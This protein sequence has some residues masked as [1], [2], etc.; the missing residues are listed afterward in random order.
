MQ[1]KDRR[2]RG[3]RVDL[4]QGGH[5]ALCE[6]KFRPAT[7]YPHPLRWGG[8]LRLIFQHPQGIRQRW[9]SVPSKLHGVI[10]ALTDRVH[11][12]IIEPR[13]DRASICVNHCCRWS[14]L[15]PQDFVACSGRTDFAGCDRDCLSK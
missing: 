14:L 2:V 7:D 3:N 15:L 8:S 6:L 12:G 5:P 1:N 11:V 13:D 9:Y 4:V 10:E